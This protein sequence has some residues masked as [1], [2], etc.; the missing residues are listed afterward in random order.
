M[1]FMHTYNCYPEEQGATSLT[2]GS[3][4]QPLGCTK[5]PG[6]LQKQDEQQQTS[7]ES[8]YQLLP[9]AGFFGELVF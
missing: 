6:F 8:V 7:R 4:I 3:L 1:A 5:T 2:T 9:C